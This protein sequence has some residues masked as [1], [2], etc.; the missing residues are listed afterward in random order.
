MELNANTIAKG[1]LLPGDPKRAQYIA[2]N[3]L[4]QT[5]EFRLDN[6]ITGYSGIYDGRRISVAGSGMGI[7]SVMLAADALYDCDD[8]NA[9]IRIGT[10]GTAQSEVNIGDM[11][12]ALGC[13]TTSG[14]NYRTFEGDLFCPVADFEMLQVA[15][16]KAVAMNIGFKV[17]NIL[18]CDLFYD[19]TESE[20][21]NRWWDFGVLGVEMEGAGLYTTALKHQKKALM[22]CTVSDSIINRQGMTPK[23][24]ETS[25]HDMI[26]LGLNSIYE[27]CD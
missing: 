8:V 13:S 5:E 2:V 24:R 26:I 3:Y 20:A 25:L 6:G 11:L 18:S 23:Q 12:I 9:I 16:D 15:T 10:C 4:K 21:N 27:F 22:I 7:P 17:G 19:L 14:I 1:V